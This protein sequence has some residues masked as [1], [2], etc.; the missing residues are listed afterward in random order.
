MAYVGLEGDPRVIPI[1]LW[2]DPD[3]IVMATVPKAAN[4][5]ALVADDTNSPQA[6]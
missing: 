1:C 6:Q 5:S 4:V 3:Q 2:P